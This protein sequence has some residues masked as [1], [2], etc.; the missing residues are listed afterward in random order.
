MRFLHPEWFL[1]LLVLP[2]LWALELAWRRW[3]QRRAVEFAEPHLAAGALPDLASG[4][5]VL[6]TVLTSLGVA[7][8]IAALARPQGPAT[9]APGFRPAL[10]LVL[11]VDGS[12]SML[13]RDVT[14]DRLGSVRREADGLLARLPGARVGLVACAGQAWLHCPLTL[15]RDAVRLALTHLDPWSLPVRGSD[16]SAGM[17][18]AL[19]KLPSLPGTA[20]AVVL[21]TDGEANRPG[22]LEDLARQARERN[23]RLYVMG[24]G[25]PAGGPIPVGRDLWGRESYRVFRGERVVTRLKTLDLRRAVQLTG[26]RL[27]TVGEGETAADLARE[28][29]RLRPATVPAGTRTL[30]REGYAPLTIL[31]LLLL[32]VEPLWPL[33]RRRA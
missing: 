6:R 3:R 28:L 22:R 5:A 7:L 20:P 15:D 31:A 30:R 27:W 2:G 4:P 33:F 19:E 12:L 13:A 24:V 17:A 18:L 11:V 8:L 1:A 16:L 32:A 9:P 23:V 21:Y 10:D 29:A 14:P 25:T 26:G